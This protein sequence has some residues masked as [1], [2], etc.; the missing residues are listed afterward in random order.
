M[1]ISL[2]KFS[3]TG[4]G[5]NQPPLPPNPDPANHTVLHAEQLEGKTILL[6]HYEGCTT[7]SGQKLLLLRHPWVGGPLD[8]HLL[9]DD[10]IVMARFEPNDQ[11]WILARLCAVASTSFNQ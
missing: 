5:T 4:R 8:P 9:G 11:G 1:G 2:F 3:E 10:H 7:F 6:V